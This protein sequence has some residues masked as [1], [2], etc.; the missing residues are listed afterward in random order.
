MVHV[1][2]VCTPSP[3]DLD[4]CCGPAI[5]V[6][7]LHATPRP[8]IGVAMLHVADMLLMDFWNLLNCCTCSVHVACN[9]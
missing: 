6:P 8:W 7:V 3:L 9:V 4:C 2:C 5:V 1:V